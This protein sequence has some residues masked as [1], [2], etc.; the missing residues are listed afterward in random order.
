MGIFDFFGIIG[1]IIDPTSS[2]KEMQDKIGFNKEE[3]VRD[4]HHDVESVE[5]EHGFNGLLTDHVNDIL[6]YESVV[7][8]DDF[9]EL[10]MDIMNDYDKNPD[11]EDGDVIITDDN[12]G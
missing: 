3:A 2:L 1:A 10:V 4:S 7:P 5:P 6:V 8:E 11:T 12:D 9:N